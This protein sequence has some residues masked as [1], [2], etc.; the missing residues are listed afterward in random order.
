MTKLLYSDHLSVAGTN[1]IVNAIVGAHTD[2]LFSICSMKDGTLITGGKDRR[3]VQWTSAYK[4][5][6]I[7]LEVLIVWVLCGIVLY[8]EIYLTF[9]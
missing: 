4:K 7:E 8:C 6:G 5:T 3:L 1:R 2:G 9:D